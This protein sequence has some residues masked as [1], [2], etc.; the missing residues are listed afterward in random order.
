MAIPKVLKNFNIFLDGFGYAGLC[1]EVKLPDLKI[2]TAEHRAGGMDLPVDLDMG[3]E[4]LEMGFTMAEQSA[5]IFR[6]FGL[7]NQNAVQCTFRA[8][9]VDDQVVEPFHLFC[10]GMYTSLNG[11]S[12]KNGEKAPLEAMLTLRY[13]RMELNGRVELE[14]DADNMKRV[15]NGVD[16]MAEIRRAIGL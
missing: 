9:K 10:R 15:I 11:G 6:Q 3:M 5:Q 4:K 12:V 2:K 7:R 8:A 13:Y 16:Q 14:I 1:D